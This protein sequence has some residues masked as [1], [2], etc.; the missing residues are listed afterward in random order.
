MDSFFKYQAK[1]EF[2][3]EWINHQR[4]RVIELFEKVKDRINCMTT[5]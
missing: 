2:N 3:Q 4:E 5:S 1:N